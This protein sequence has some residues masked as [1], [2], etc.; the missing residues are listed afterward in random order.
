M[1]KIKVD[2]NITSSDDILEEMYNVTKFWLP[3]FR[4]DL[5]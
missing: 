5:Y 3:S 4:G 2:L 1:E